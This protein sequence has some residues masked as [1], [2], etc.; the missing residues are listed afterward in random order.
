MNNE[1]NI[2]QGPSTSPLNPAV[3]ASLNPSSLKAIQL[4]NFLLWA[5]YSGL[6]VDHR[7]LDFNTH[8]Y[9]I[10]IYN[11][12][13]KEV[14][15]MK[16]AQMG[17]TIYMLLK[18][19]WYAW[20]GDTLLDPVKIGF[21]F[22]T[23]GG[24]TALSKDRF[25]PLI[26]SNPYL[27]DCVQD[28]TLYF[29]KIGNCS[30]YL[31]HVGGVDSKD[32]TPLDIIAFDEVR[33][34]N[35]ADISQAEERISHS[36]HKI[37]LFMSTAGFPGVDIHKRF[38]D[39]NQKYWH[40]NCRCSDG[41]VLADHFP[42]CIAERGGEKFYICPKCRTRIVDPQ[43]GQYI[44]HNPRSEVEGFHVSQLVSKY[45]TIFD[46]WKKFTTTDNMKEFY[47]SVLGLPFIDKENQPVT[48]EIL[49]RCIR[50]DIPWVSSRQRTCMGV[51]QMAGMNYVV[52][53]KKIGEKKRLVYLEVIDDSNPVY[54]EAGKRVTPFARLYQLMREFDVSVC[55]I[56]AEP[57]TNEAL[58]FCNSFPGRVFLAWYKEATGQN[59]V[60]WS[61]RGPVE[62]RKFRKGTPSIKT[63]WWVKIDRYF[64]IDLALKEYVSQK[65]EV[66]NPNS[67]VQNVRSVKTGS[68]EPHRLCRDILF[69]HLTKVVR[70][71]KEVGENT[72]HYKLEWVNLGLDPHFLHASVYANIAMERLAGIFNIDFV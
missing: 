56:D 30:I 34:I 60:T 4:N 9:L 17:A 62:L 42:D 15:W 70:H 57:N 7:K 33:L 13:S 14:V 28:D 72:G 19:I 26:Q 2:I 1:N 48:P 59:P 64:G 49:E 58:E 37:K 21:Y 35:P 61:D 46:I 10:D 50:S 29:K 20:R 5:A 24:L 31:K 47:N 66:P 67:L 38:L 40:S 12:N 51:D 55:V 71:R 53:T 22:P 65:M 54:W 68:F 44:A 11:T 43:N 39:S 23:H 63:K 3:I 18:V 16:A 32:S 69:D 27:R 36:R 41:V 6:E 25:T 52:I 45:I 8:R